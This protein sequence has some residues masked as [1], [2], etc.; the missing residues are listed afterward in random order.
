MCGLKLKDRPLGYALKAHLRAQHDYY[1]DLFPHYC[2]TCGL[3]F[4]IETEWNAHE[5]LHNET[6]RG[7]STFPCVLCSQVFE[8]IVLLKA[9]T[10]RDHKDLAKFKCEICGKTF[11]SPN[12]HQAHV[13]LHEGDGY[14]CITCGKMFSKIRA[15]QDH[16][17]THLAKE[18]R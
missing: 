13:R 4:N 3:G 1:N 17:T 8:N 6:P 15:L 2:S 9:H 7:S 10:K 5:L 14:K 18:Q 16:E 12:S 11:V